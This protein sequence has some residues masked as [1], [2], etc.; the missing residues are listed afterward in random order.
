VDAQA[1]MASIQAELTKSGNFAALA[2][3]HSKGPE[4]STGGDLG[5]LGDSPEHKIFLQATA[6]LQTGDVSPR[7][8][9]SPAGLNVLKVEEVRAPRQKAYEEIKGQVARDML[10]DEHG[11]AK[12]K[13]A[14]DAWLAKLKGGVDVERISSVRPE[15]APGQPVAPPP[16]DRPYLETTDWITR[17]L[18]AIPRIGIDRRLMGDIFT[19]ADDHRLLEK[20]YR[21]GR[22]FYVVWLAERQQPDMGQFSMAVTYL[23]SSALQRKSNY[24]LSVWLKAMREQA[25]VNINQGLVSAR[26]SAS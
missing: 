13:T 2:K 16:L 4:A 11:A 8:V 15:A 24:V 23:R 22:H 26:Q 7:A 18:Q 25:E 21:V 5:W 10:L 20:V 3:K 14:A 12:A 6:S 19:L 9:R 17:D 1:T